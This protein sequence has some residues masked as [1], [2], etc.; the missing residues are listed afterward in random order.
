MSKV[1][2]PS[3]ILVGTQVFE[4]IFRT[5]K[6]DGML[7]EGSCGYTLDN[8][9]VIVID[10]TLPWSKQRQTFV[11]E[12]LHAMRMVFGSQTKPKKTDSFEDWEH[13]F[14]GIYEEVLLVVLR[15]NPGIV[16]YLTA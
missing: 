1:T 6:E 13:Y 10:A 14:I 9:S 16:E 3:Q 12:M 5:P 4:V 11:H 2:A 8:E 15:D 7:S